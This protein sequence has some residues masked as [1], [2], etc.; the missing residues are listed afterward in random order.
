MSVQ[1]FSDPIFRRH[2]V[3]LSA[4]AVLTPQLLMSLG[5]GIILRWFLNAQKTGVGNCPILGILDIT[6]TIYLMVG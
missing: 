4:G 3:I 2:E 5:D 1:I 6:V